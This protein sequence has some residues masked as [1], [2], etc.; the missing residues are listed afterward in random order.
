MDWSVLAHAVADVVER[1]LFGVDSCG[2]L[3]IVN[4]ALE[5]LLGWRREQLVGQDW[6]EAILAAAAPAA[7]ELV[8]RLA[9]GEAATA[10]LH[11]RS[12]GG[13]VW[14]ATATMWASG[15]A[16]TDGW[17]VVVEAATA[18]DARCAPTFEA[19]RRWSEIATPEVGAWFVLRDQRGVAPSP[20]PRCADHFAMP[21]T[22]CATCPLRA[23]QRLAPGERG[24]AV[25]AGA[26]G[27]LVLVH[28]WR[29]SAETALVSHEALGGATVADLARS[30][31]AELAASALLSVRERE[32]LEHLVLGASLEQIAEAL[33]ISPRTAKFHQA[34]TLNKLGL[35]S[36]LELPRLLIEHALSRP[37]S[38]DR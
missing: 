27:E 26:H 5:Q 38:S 36:R 34:N 13:V 19:P 9:T 33:G 24:S 12:R 31:L 4:R 37:V 1:P 8:A 7:A 10:T 28:A 32:V 21:D 18:S 23:P 29:T 6:T 11:L 16:V 35:A 14:I 22:A 15:A 30:R 20:A 3:R 17:V 2:R 25:V